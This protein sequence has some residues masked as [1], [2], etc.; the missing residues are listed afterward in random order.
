M[1]STR[2]SSS[3]SYTSVLQWLTY[4]DWTN[5]WSVSKFIQNLILCLIVMMMQ[6]SF[7]IFE[8]ITGSVVNYT[9]HFS[10]AINMTIP[11]RCCM[12]VQGWST[13]YC[14]SDCR[15]SWCQQCQYYVNNFHCKQAGIWAT[16]GI[17]PYQLVPMIVSRLLC[18]VQ[19]CI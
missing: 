13:P 8:G 11:V 1:C 17:W 3:Q 15:W 10:S 4:F 7:S 5:C 2:A 18:V 12:W 9:I 6:N 16:F 14:L 19:S